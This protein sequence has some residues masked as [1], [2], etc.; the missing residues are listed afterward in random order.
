M[1]TPLGTGV[2]RNW[3]RLCR[4]ESGIGPITH[5]D[6]SACRTRIAGEVKD[7]E[8]ADFMEKKTVRRT[9]RFI[10]LAA[11]AARMAVEDAGLEITPGNADSIGVSIGTA[12]GGLENFEK[13]HSLLLDG[14]RDRVSPF[15]VPGLIC[16]MAAGEIAIRYGAKGPLLCS[17]TAC[18]AGTHSIGEA[19]RVIREGDA[20][21]M[22]AGGAEAELIPT[23]FAGLDALKVMS[24]RN[25]NPAG[26]VR[27]FD[28]ER[29]GFVCSEGAGVLVMEEMKSAQ[30]RGARIYAEVL[31]YGNNCDAYHITSPDPEAR[32]AA[33]CMLKAVKDA[34]LT[35]E[36][37]E[38][39][40]AH[41]TST[42]ANDQG[43]TRAIKKVFGELA[44]KVP[45]TGSKSMLGHLWG[46]AGSVEAIISILTI[47]NGII[48]PTI[49]YENPDPECDLDYVPNTARRVKIDNVL[50]NSFGF[51]GTNGCLVFGR[52]EF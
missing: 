14:S 17:V 51:G 8:A 19:L 15:F 47:V 20:E 22:L 28:S 32:G 41:G 9:T 6:S 45:V 16:N 24:A 29:D 5:F 42:L 52:S 11:A 39:I 7:F 49:N 46:A 40:N 37:I 23:L 35:P 44:G 21:A 43:E 34:G 48:P 38:H 1:V 50:S 4:G 10:H 27:P 2:E 18:A 26:A 30:K 25:D 3:E 12:L 33:L 36:T 13:N 31:G